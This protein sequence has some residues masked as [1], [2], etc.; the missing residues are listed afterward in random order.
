M[1]RVRKHNASANANANANANA[2]ATVIAMPNLRPRQYLADRGVGF[3]VINIAPHVTQ[4]EIAVVVPYCRHSVNFK[5]SIQTK[6]QMFKCTNA[7]I[8]A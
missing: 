1:K 5:H 4:T 7:Q 8:R 6:A 3:G 2:D